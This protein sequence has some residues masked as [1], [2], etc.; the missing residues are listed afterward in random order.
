MRAA[1]LFST[2]S[3]NAASAAEEAEAAAAV[4]DDGDD[5]EEAEAKGAVEE[6]RR[7]KQLSLSQPV[8]STP[9]PQ[10]CSPPRPARI[11]HI[12]QKGRRRDVRRSSH[13]H[14][15][16]IKIIHFERNI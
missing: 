2:L 4:E 1:C 3:M 12:S 5:D 9:P 7:E 8:V 14:H 6:R 15:H 16:G 10:D 11:R 13:Q